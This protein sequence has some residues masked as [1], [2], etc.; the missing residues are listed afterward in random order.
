MCHSILFCFLFSSIDFFALAQDTLPFS[1]E[2]GGIPSSSLLPTWASTSMV[3]V[4]DPQRTE[5]RTVYF[6]ATTGFAVT[7]TL[8]SYQGLSPAVWVAS[9]WVLEFSTN[10]SAPTPLL[11]NVS[12]LN[13]TLVDPVGGS[14][15][16]TELRRYRGSFASPLDYS[17]VNQTLA[18]NATL[19][20]TPSPSPSPVPSPPPPL[21]PGIRVWG[22]VTSTTRASTPEACRDDC[23]AAGPTKCNSMAWANITGSYVGCWLCLFD[24]TEEYPGF[25]SWIAPPSP[26][27]PPP[28]PTRTAS[29]K[30]STGRSS[31]GELPYFGAFVPGTGEGRQF[32]IGW[33]GNWVAGAARDAVGGGT[34]ITVTHPT[35]CSSLL[36]GEPPL[37]SMRV[38]DIAYNASTP[39]SYHAGVNAHRRLMTRYKVP[40]TPGG[41]EPQGA[42]V[43][44]WSWAGWDDGPSLEGQLFH[45]AAVKNSS[46]VEA[47][48][49][50]AG[51]FWGAFP[52]GVGNWQLPIN[53][54]VD[55][56][57]FP[58]GS[59]AP[60]GVAAHSQPNPVKFVTW[61]EPER[62]AKGTWI[63][64]HHPEFLLHANYTT[65]R[66]L[67]LG[68]T[69]ARGF[70]TTYLSSA[71]GNY[72]LDVLRV[73]FNFDPAPHWVSGDAALG[74]N[75]SGITEMR[76]IAGL[77]Q[78]WDTCL[79][80]HPGLMIDDCSSGGR[81]IDLETLSRAVPLWRSDDPGTAEQQ[82]VQSMGLSGFAPLS[83][84]G[85]SSWLPYPWRSSGITGKTIDWGRAG[86]EVL[87]NDTS[88]M[89]LLRA[90][91]AE[92]Q[93]LRPLAIFGDFFPLTPIALGGGNW[94]L[95]WAAYQLHCPQNAPPPRR[96]VAAG[97][98][99]VPGTGA[100]FVFLRPQGPP[101]GAFLAHLYDIDPLSACVAT[102]SYDYSVNTTL[103]VTGAQLATLSI[104]FEFGTTSQSV[105]LE[106]SCA[107]AAA[108]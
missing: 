72:S 16:T 80:E 103:R 43:A 13:V 56:K 41:G 96:V 14:Q 28:L 99:C 70:I 101:V 22:D 63:D 7:H 33:S 100:A 25:V 46:S 1:F 94:G 50:D 60:L 75:R 44:S 81:R 69:D 108:V 48:W 52:N 98:A 66:L 10:G 107:A 19:P 86:W 106:Y 105:L 53:G 11:C 79:A 15:G 51:W 83:S 26:P 92:T 77:Y 85:V 38:V 93:R 23:L 47:Y 3:T 78:M 20:P 87:L 29:W 24:H 62:V 91:V 104:P 74:S 12:P 18:S 40:R 45:V 89:A 6:D 39:Q 27:P 21:L 17:G 64:V 31:D 95:E 37:R 67:N 61:F 30:P 54:T 32:S 34:Q 55:T 36:P 58:G 42:L 35:L 82:Q 102:L 73:D 97:G 71:V 88:Q 76:Y 4:I 49:L 65:D 90:A 84:G 57:K 59:L 9:E 68:N 2:L 5:N 8:L